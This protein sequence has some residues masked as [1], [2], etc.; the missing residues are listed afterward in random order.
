M[1]KAGWIAGAALLAAPH[2]LG[3]QA[4][5]GPAL[6]RLSLADAVRLA[7]DTSASVVIG[8][9]RVAEA[10]ARVLQARAVLL[11]DVTA[12]ANVVN[13]D[14]NLKD[15]GF[16][17]PTA[18]GADPLP[19]RAGPVTVYNARPRASQTLYDPASLVRLRAARAQVPA[20][21]A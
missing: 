18:P 12:T 14:S 8:G 5:E 9:L 13:Q 4:G 20:A 17:F 6:V 11:P 7:S 1:R 21:G 3:A 10:E 15:F 16:S 2:V 19:D